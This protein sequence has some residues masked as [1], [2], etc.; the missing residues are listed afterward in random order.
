MTAT[1]PTDATR[2]ARARRRRDR[3]TLLT[4]YVGIVTRKN[5]GGQ[6]PAEVLDPS[7]SLQDED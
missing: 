3:E 5:D 1:S 2:V 6:T 7:F 4:R